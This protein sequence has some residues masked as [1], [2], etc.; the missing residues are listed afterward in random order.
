[1]IKLPVQTGREMVEVDFIVVDVY[2]LYMAI[3]ARPWLHAM[4]AVS[5]T[6]HVKVKYRFGRGEMVLTKY[7]S[8]L[9]Y[10]CIIFR[11]IKV[12]F[13]DPCR[14]CILCPLRL[15]PP[16]PNDTKLKGSRPV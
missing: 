16:F 9:Y 13:Y 4:G 12:I 6:V 2:A 15:E 8:R 7:T 14:Y 10:I 11:F 3:L 5:S 1:M